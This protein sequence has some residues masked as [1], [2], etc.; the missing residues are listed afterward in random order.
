MN[1]KK[2]KQRPVTSPPPKENKI[3][4]SKAQAEL[5]KFMEEKLYGKLTLV[6]EKG[7]PKRILNAEYSIKLRNSSI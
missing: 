3:F 6:I 5:L 7:E 2:I 4:L 1:N